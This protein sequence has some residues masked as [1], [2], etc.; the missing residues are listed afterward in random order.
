MQ[1]L[2]GSNALSGVM[3]LGTNGQLVLDFNT[4]EWFVTS[5]GNSFNINLGSGV[6]CSGAV[7]YTQG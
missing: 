7:Y 6:Q 1:F 3:S 4:T 2:D 5:P